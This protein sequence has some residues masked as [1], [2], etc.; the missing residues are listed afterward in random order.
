MWTK[1]ET[2]NYVYETGPLWKHEVDLFA[3]WFDLAIGTDYAVE[4]QGPN[5]A[6]TEW[7]DP[8][9]HDQWIFMGYEMTQREV[10]LCTQLEDAFIDE[11]D[12][13]KTQ[14]VS[15]FLEVC[16]TKGLFTREQLI[17]LVDETIDSGE[18]IFTGASR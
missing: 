14:Y 17:L 16:I 2:E 1:Y 8:D 4:N 18:H 12:C 11:S 5:D 10:D 9:S 7:V 13:G 6:S 15:D 3:K